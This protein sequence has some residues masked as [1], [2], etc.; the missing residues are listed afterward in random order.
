MDNKRI[1]WL[2]LY[3]DY[4]NKRY[5]EA[6]KHIIAEKNW[7]KSYSWKFYR[8]SIF[9]VKIKKNASMIINTDII[10]ILS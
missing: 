10:L 9:F 6:R 8:I 5:T 2:I 3:T 7:D 1:A 4:R